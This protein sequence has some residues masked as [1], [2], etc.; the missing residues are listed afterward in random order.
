MLLA[1]LCAAWSLFVFMTTAESRQNECTTALCVLLCKSLGGNSWWLLSWHLLG[2]YCK[3]MTT[4]IIINNNNCNNNIDLT[5]I[6]VTVTMW[7]EPKVISCACEAS[8][9]PP[10]RLVQ[11]IFLPNQDSVVHTVASTPATADGLWAEVCLVHMSAQQ[12]VWCEGR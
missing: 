6:V 10:D 11:T 8:Q 12:V 4:T 7:A 3:S 9:L 2:A 5:I 1:D